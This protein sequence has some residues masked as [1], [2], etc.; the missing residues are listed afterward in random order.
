MAGHLHAI[1]GFLQCVGAAVG[2]VNAFVKV[3]MTE[4]RVRHEIHNGFNLLGTKNADAVVTM[5]I[6]SDRQQ[7]LGNAHVQM[8]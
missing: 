5:F 8:E 3:E 1:H 4:I 2:R 7:F 6:E